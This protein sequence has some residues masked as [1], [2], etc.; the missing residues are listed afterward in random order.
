M[1]LTKDE[2]LKNKKPKEEKI[3][4]VYFLIFENEIIYVG[5]SSNTTSRILTHITNNIFNFDSYY[6]N[7]CNDYLLQETKYILRFKPKKNT[8]V[9]TKIALKLGLIC[10]TLIKKIMI[11][12]NNKFN[13][14][15]YHNRFIRDIKRKVTKENLYILE[16]NS[17][18]FYREKD[19]INLA[20]SF[21]E[22]ENDLVVEK[23]KAFI[24]LL[25][26][27]KNGN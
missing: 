14:N 1:Y 16:Y 19:I 13:K 22:F 11:K 12:M 9:D 27:V 6:I 20:K 10:K 25:E 24:E 15:Y 4:G 23:Q 18:N 7:P 17:L 26:E 5:C 3:P 21:F 8:V 2:I